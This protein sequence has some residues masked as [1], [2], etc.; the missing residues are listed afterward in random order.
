MKRDFGFAPNPFHGFCTLACCKPKIRS[1]ASIGDWIVGTSPTRVGIDNRLVYVMQVAEVL[2]FE[3]YWSDS[4][5][6]LKRPDFNGCLKR[7][8][9]DN[10]YHHDPSSGKWLQENSHHSLKDG[11]TNVKNLMQDTGST[12]RVIVATTFAYWGGS[13]PTIP[14]DFDQGD[15]RRLRKIGPHHKSNFAPE[16]VREFL[17]WFHSMKMQ[18]VYAK[19]KDWNL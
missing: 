9:G 6:V 1:S 16:F 4:R 10:I 18:G 8:Y 7:A 13:G 11:L 3:S 14:T 5:F 15:H 12:D 17:S 2:T 19:P